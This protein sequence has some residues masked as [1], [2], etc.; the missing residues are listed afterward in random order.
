L[1]AA[2]A[3]L[4]AWTAVGWVRAGEKIGEF[5]DRTS[6]KTAELQSTRKEL[7]AAGLLYKA[8]QKSLSEV[9]DSLYQETRLQ[10]KSE[11]KRHTQTIWRLEATE[12]DT[13]LDLKR[14]KRRESEATAARKRQALPPA[15]S[16][17]GALVCGGLLLF[18]A[19]PRGEPA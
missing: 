1:V 17:A 14:L 13:M 3:G 6:E 12:R 8:Y 16:G 4:L 19:R 7:N 10:M 15:A 5:R 9:P 11:R 18:S 2:G